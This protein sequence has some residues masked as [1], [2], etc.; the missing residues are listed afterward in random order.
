LNKLV[1]TALLAV[2]FLGGPLQSQSTPAAKSLA[3]ETGT[4]TNAVCYADGSVNFS[5]KLP[6]GQQYVELFSRNNGIQ[7]IA[8]AIV[9]GGVV[10]ADGTTTYAYSAK[11]YKTGDVVEYRFYSYL[12][13]APG[14]FTPGPVE[15]KWNSLVVPHLVALPDT[16]DASLYH[17]SYYLGD[18]S[19]KNYGS[20][21][22]LAV[23]SY[24]DYAD[25]IL[26]F[27]LNGFPSDSVITKARLIL[28]VHAMKAG[29]GDV[30]LS[31]VTDSASWDEMTVTSRTTP[32]STLFGSYTFPANGEASLDVTAL[33]TDA[34]AAGKS[35]LSFLLTPSGGIFSIDSK[36][37]TSG[38]APVL[39]VTL[40]P[41]PTISGAINTVWNADQSVKSCFL[42]L[43]WT[44]PAGFEG[45]VDHYELY[46]S[47]TNGATWNPWLNP[48]SNALS[49]VWLPNQH[50]TVSV[51]AVDKTGTRSARSNALTL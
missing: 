44:A 48:T 41:A 37:T 49:N 2:S 7:N 45:N 29:A 32:A 50:V 34:V 5:V 18:L 39:E 38:K 15:S 12:P 14:V 25:A 31:Q 51:I 24:L 4:N 9:D 47:S 16:K 17:R 19:N 23:M 26:G 20:T 40:S 8:Q 33:V 10:N 28:N 42:A 30:N 43:N 27:G 13:A 46:V 36:E 6:S 21:T 3:A 22:A 35:E 1:L 11:G